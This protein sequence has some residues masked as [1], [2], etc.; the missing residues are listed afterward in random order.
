MLYSVYICGDLYMFRQK[1]KR[2]DIDSKKFIFHIKPKLPAVNPMAQKK[3]NSIS[4]LLSE[5]I[6]PN[7]TLILWAIWSCTLSRKQKSNTKNFHVEDPLIGSSRTFIITT[8][9]SVILLV[10]IDFEVLEEQFYLSIS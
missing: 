8:Y 7:T 6:E 10:K 3:I 4:S 9:L 5:V 2:S 1:L